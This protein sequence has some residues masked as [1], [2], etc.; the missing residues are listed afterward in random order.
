MHAVQHLQHVQKMNCA[1]HMHMQ[2]PH[3]TE[4]IQ[5]SALCDPSEPSKSSTHKGPEDSHFRRAMMTALQFNTDSVLTP[6]T[7]AKMKTVKRLLAD[8]SFSHDRTPAFNLEHIVPRALWVPEPSRPS[9][10]DKRVVYPV[11]RDL[12]NLCIARSLANVYRGHVSFGMGPSGEALRAADANFLMLDGVA[13]IR[14]GSGVPNIPKQSGGASWNFQ[15]V[16]VVPEHDWPHAALRVPGSHPP[17]LSSSKEMLSLRAVLTRATVD[18]WDRKCHTNTTKWKRCFGTSTCAQD[19]LS[20]WQP[21]YITRGQLARDVLNIIAM[22]VCNHN[23]YNRQRMEVFL[24]FLPVWITWDRDY[25]VE[26]GEWQ[27]AISRLSFT[28]TINPFVV[29]R[30]GVDT[31]FLTLPALPVHLSGVLFAAPDTEAPLMPASAMIK[32]V[33]ILRAPRRAINARFREHLHALKKSLTAEEESSASSAGSAVVR[34]AT[35][36]RK[37]RRRRKR[38]GKKADTADDDVVESVSKST[39]VVMEKHATM[40]HM[41]NG[42]AVQHN[43]DLLVAEMNKKGTSTSTAVPSSPHEESNEWCTVM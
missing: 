20:V 19:A 30:L 23:N 28:G 40:K 43:A 3:E 25:K 8:E 31:T 24:R 9:E 42:T 32:L 39:M 6:Y 18:G 16:V 4:N 22:Y 36:I 11:E 7:L 33:T 2:A 1:S 15:R 26:K 21:P 12:H 5:F 13:Y 14:K 17:R 38:G 34:A 37:R 29:W 41:S 10:V 35:K 27:A